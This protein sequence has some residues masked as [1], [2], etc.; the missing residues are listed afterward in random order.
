[1]PEGNSPPY[2]EEPKSELA[3]LPADENDL[4]TGV[5]L[6]G[7]QVTKNA[8][9]SQ[10]L[11]LHSSQRQWTLVITQCNTSCGSQWSTCV[12]YSPIPLS[13]TLGETPSAGGKKRE[14]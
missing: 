14:D 2:L 12:A 4:G 1:M 3:L 10:A 9:L 5:N 13:V 8:I 7:S 11:V 6:N